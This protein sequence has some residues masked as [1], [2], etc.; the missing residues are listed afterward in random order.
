[1]GTLPM[2]ESQSSPSGVIIATLKRAGEVQTGSV[3]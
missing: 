3:A 1:V 2:V